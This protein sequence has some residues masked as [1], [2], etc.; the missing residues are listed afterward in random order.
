MSKINLK[1]MGNKNGTKFRAINRF[2]DVEKMNGERMLDFLVD[3]YDY[4]KFSAELRN[5]YNR[6][7]NFYNAK[8]FIDG[9]DNIINQF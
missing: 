8:T 9:I 4:P 5:V 3:H 6:T 1:Q 2:K 7:L